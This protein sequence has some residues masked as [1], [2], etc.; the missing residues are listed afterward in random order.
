M[1]T[2]YFNPLLGRTTFAVSP[3]RFSPHG[4][5]FRTFAA[6][7]L[8]NT[9]SEDYGREVYPAWSVYVNGISTLPPEQGDRES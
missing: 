4:S 3:L 5:P 7:S 8:S 9:N 2:E 6:V 1:A